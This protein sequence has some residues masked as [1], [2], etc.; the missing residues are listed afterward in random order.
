MK[1]SGVYNKAACCDQ[2]ILY[3]ILY[4]FY[5]LLAL[6]LVVTCNS[7]TTIKSF[8]CHIDHCRMDAAGG[9]AGKCWDKDGDD[10]L[11]KGEHQH[12]S[13]NPQNKTLQNIQ[14]DH[15]WK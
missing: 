8:K 10:E 11:R 12:Y 4:F 15:I 1:N 3:I 2:V 7:I 14:H 6:T 13:N 5:N 9:F